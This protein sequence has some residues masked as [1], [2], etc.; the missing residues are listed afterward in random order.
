MVTSSISH[1]ATF[2]FSYQ[3]YFV[4]FKQIP[5]SQCS[6]KNS[7]KLEGKMEY[8]EGFSVLNT[9]NALLEAQNKCE[10][11]RTEGNISSIIITQVLPGGSVARQ[12]S[13][14]KRCY[15]AMVYV[16]LKNEMWVY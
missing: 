13:E 3:K 7:L 16:S 14:E 6:V 5:F 2:P 9:E 15:F 12:I 10:S 8:V 4:V 1:G 11:E